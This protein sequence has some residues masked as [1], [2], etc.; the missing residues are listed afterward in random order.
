[1]KNSTVGT[2]GA[3]IFMILVVGG[4][5]YVWKTA[6]D[7]AS[8]SGG[9][10]ETYSL[11]DLSG[12]KSQAQTLTTGAENNAGLPLPVPTAKLGKTNP[13]SAPE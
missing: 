13:Y 3:L 4:F 5:Y 12:M 11:V 6:S 10:T 9:A 7:V 2:I 8:S 1:M